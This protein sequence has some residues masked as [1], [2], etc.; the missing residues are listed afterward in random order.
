MKT[1]KPKSILIA[2]L[3]FSIALMYGVMPPMPRANAVDSMT[4][5]SDTIS[6]SNLGNAT[7]THTIV[8]TTGTTTPSGGFFNIDFPNAITNIATTSGVQC[9]YSWQASLFTASS[10]A[11]SNMIDCNVGGGGLTPTTTRIIVYGTTNP[12]TDGSQVLEVR[13]YYD[14]T[15]FRE[16]IQL[17]VY[18]LEDVTMTARVTATLSFSVSGT[19]SAAVVN[20]AGCDYS[21]TATTTDFGT[22]SLVAS[23]TIC[24]KLQVATNATD[25]YI[26]TVEQDAELT[27]SGGDN[28][29]S[30][31]DAPTGQGSST[32]TYAWQSPSAVLDD[33]KTYGHMGLTSDDSDLS[34]DGGLDFTGENYAGLNG[35][36]VMMVLA[37]DGPTTDNEQDKGFAHVAYTAEIS[38]LQEAGDYESTITY[39]ATATY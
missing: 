32:A 17:P 27:S 7:T 24:Q 31:I 3:V 35:T 4:A 23:T 21:T 11:G 9:G 5:A 18:F 14:N 12:S 2:L 16:R 10:S 39:I 25:G 15:E 29:N 34:S 37:H 20:G 6:N 28:I 38:A 8:F 13:N 26:V 33:Y 36:D 22:L 1:K 30:F 19:T